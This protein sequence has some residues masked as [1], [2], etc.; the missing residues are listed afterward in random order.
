ME[1]NNIFDEYIGL[2]ILPY[3][4]QRINKVIT[5]DTMR[6]SLPVSDNACIGEFLHIHIYIYI[7][8]CI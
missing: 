7:C 2:F 4:K 5:L 1:I 3:S 8:S 6:F